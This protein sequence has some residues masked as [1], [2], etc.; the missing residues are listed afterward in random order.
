[1][2]GQQHA[3]AALYPL[4]RPQYPFYRLPLLVVIHNVR[5]TILTFVH[6]TKNCKTGSKEVDVE[7][8]REREREGG[9]I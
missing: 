4:E 3:P 7:R 5:Q 9:G 8:E 6:Y 1:V 2:S